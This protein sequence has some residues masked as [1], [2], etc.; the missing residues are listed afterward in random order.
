MKI[1]YLE[2]AIF[3]DNEVYIT[4]VTIYPQITSGLTMEEWAK[5]NIDGYLIG[6]VKKITDHRLFLE[7][8]GAYHLA[9]NCSIIGIKLDGNQVKEVSLSEA[10]VPSG[11]TI[12]YNRTFGVSTIYV[13]Y[14]E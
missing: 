10:E 8:G 7:N 6:T 11:A 12:Y 9:N 14:T 2:D 13:E 3:N 4:D 1:G 5:R